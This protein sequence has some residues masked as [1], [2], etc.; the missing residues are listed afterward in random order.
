LVQT[1]GD[2]ESKVNL[3]G[4]FKPEEPSQV[5]TEDGKVKDGDEAGQKMDT[6]ELHSEDRM[7]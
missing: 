1:E 3:I 4:L 5:V 7:I 6:T 2:E